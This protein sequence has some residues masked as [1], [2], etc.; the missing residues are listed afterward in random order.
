MDQEIQRYTD[1]AA[2][3]ATEAGV[4]VVAAI[5]FWIVGRWL[6]GLAG[7]MLQ[8]VLEP[9]KVDPTLMLTRAA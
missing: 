2:A 7:R 6:I 3:Y 8:R 5:A 9:Q 1:I 4:K